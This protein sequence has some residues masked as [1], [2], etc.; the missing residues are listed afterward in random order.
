MAPRSELWGDEMEKLDLTDE[1][2]Q[3]ILLVGRRFLINESTRPDDLKAVLIQ[4]LR[5]DQPAL[6]GKIQ[7]MSN[8]QMASLCQMILAQQHSYA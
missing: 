5:D 1:D 6:T 8:P 4:R 2:M 7:Q 3:R